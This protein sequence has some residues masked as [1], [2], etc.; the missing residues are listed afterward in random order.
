MEEA[1]SLQ[2]ATVPVDDSS[3]LPRAADVAYPNVESADGV[4]LTLAGGER[5]ILDACA[6]GAAT[7]C[8]GHGDSAVIAAAAE[9]SEQVPYTYQHHFTNAAQERLAERLT[10]DLMPEMA[11]VRFTTGG[12]EANET[13]LRLVRS[14]QVERGDSDRWKVIS[15][16]QAYHGSLIGTLALT[17]RPSLRERWSPYLAGH[18]HLATNWREDPDGSK[19]LAELDRLIE[20]AGP[21]TVAAYFCEPV[22]GAAA[23]AMQPPAAFWRGLDERRREHGFLVVFD[24]IVCGMGRTGSWLASQQMPITPDIVTI[25]KGLGAGYAGI[26]AVL[27]TQEVY[28]PI[29]QGSADFEHGHTWDGA[30]L[31]CAV[32]NAVIDRLQEIDALARVRA[33]G[34]RMLAALREALADNRLVRE[35]RGAGLLIGIELADPAG[36]SALARVC[37]VEQ[38]VVA[39]GLE[40]DILLAATSTSSDGVVGD[41]VMLAP[42]FT[43]TDEE[44]DEMVARTAAVLR[45]IEWEL[46]ASER[47][48]A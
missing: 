10:T 12:S 43:A 40:Q 24:E 38:L 19:A 20:E 25:G 27:C 39:R 37:D 29:A 44:L 31:P 21:E 23:P 15:P 30:P 6:G 3:V 17:G 22:S 5:R 18:L 8:L 47:G 7:T 1:M 32:G 41:Q 33:A 46:G 4:W 26:A 35:V 9:Q 48:E 28:D 2:A 42:A 34:E 13:A 36:V 45:A 16:S 11:R 14:Y